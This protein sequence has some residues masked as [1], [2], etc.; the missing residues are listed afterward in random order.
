MRF[1]AELPEKLHAQLAS[2]TL[3][4]LAGDAPD[5]RALAREIAESLANGPLR[6][7]ARVLGD[8]DSPPKNEW[9]GVR[10]DLR[11]ASERARTLAWRASSVE[12]FALS[13]KEARPR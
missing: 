6:I 2:G 9:T 4:I 12:A 1:S 3:W 10:L 11:D 7:A 8:A 13:A 5:E